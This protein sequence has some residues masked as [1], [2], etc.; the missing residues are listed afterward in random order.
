MVIHRIGPG[1]VR[2][3]APA[4]LNGADGGTEDESHN[5]LSSKGE[6]KDSVELSKQG[7]A[8]AAALSGNNGND[9][10]AKRGAEI[11][12]RIESAFYDEPDVALEVAQRLNDSGD[13]HDDPLSTD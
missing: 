3:I 5:T 9:A 11:R 6:R 2:A 7:L 13:L 12:S 1:L 4:Q 8:R 10:V